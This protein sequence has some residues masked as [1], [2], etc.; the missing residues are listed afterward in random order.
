M[1]YGSSHTGVRHKSSVVDAC[2]SSR[3]GIAEQV[4][5]LGAGAVG[6]GGINDVLRGANIRKA[7]IAA[8]F[9]RVFGARN[10]FGETPVVVSSVAGILRVL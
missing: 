3:E 7:L 1:S 5:E 9:P 6:H 4:C 2:L 8:V 10:N